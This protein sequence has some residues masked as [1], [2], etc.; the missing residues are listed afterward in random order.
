MVQ[1]PTDSKSTYPLLQQFCIP[2]MLSARLSPLHI[3][4]GT[5]LP[6]VPTGVNERENTARP[7]W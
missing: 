6:Q 1:F 3:A 7:L 5:L 2:T 4:T